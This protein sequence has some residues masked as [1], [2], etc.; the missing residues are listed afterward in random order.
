MRTPHYFTFTK[1]DL[2]TKVNPPLGKKED[3]L[4]IKEGLSDETIDVIASDYAPPPRKTG[5]AG[6][7]S[8]IPLSYGLVSEGVLSKK[9]LKEKLCLNPKKIME[10]GGYKLEI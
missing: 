9:Q 5:I 8:F 6:F 1:D 7:K 10:S 3:I 2:D 4:A